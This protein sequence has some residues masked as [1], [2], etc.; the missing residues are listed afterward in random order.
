[1]DNKEPLDPLEALDQLDRLVMLV[2]Q[3]L[4]EHQ[5]TQVQLGQ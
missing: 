4:L 3:V 1:M 2:Q 5:A